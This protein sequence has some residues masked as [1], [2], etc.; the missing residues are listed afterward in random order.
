[1]RVLVTGCSGFVG[2]N[3]V[4]ALQRKGHNVVG[5]DRRQYASNDI[6]EFIK[7][8]LKDCDA[9][10]KACGDVDMIIHLAAAKDD[11]GISR[12]E[13]FRNN[14]EATKTLIEI[15][16]DAG[17]RDWIFY[18]SVAVMGPSAEKRDESSQMAPE[19][20]YGESKAEA[21]L[22]FREATRQDGEMR[23][24]IFRPAIIY[25]PGHYS[26]TNVYRLVEKI[27]NNRFAMVGNGETIK[28]MSYIQNTIS[29]TLHLLENM[30]ESVEVYNY[31]D[32]PA[33]SNGE[34]V[35]K[36]YQILDKRELG[37]RI[38]VGLAKALTL[39]IDYLAEW[40]GANFPI[41]AARIERFT[42]PT[43][44]DSSLIRELG[45]EQPVHPEEAL[46]RTIDWHMHHVA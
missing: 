23:T 39:G 13:F 6:D 28:S 20:D 40:T 46:R 37:V 7:A 22:L 21:E 30:T 27:R 9:V 42:T 43:N 3:L 15:G 5:I 24:V 25:G 14:V 11:W 38:P 26:Y 19:S 1:M 10:R 12:E 29:A 34:V 2:C 31:T 41:T 36:I 32:M 35:S 17:V 4:P 8:D 18:S 44:Y 16:R 33:L 45:F